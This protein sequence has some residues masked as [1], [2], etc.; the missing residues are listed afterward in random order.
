MSL[1][2]PF[3]NG[4]APSHTA[5]NQRILELYNAAVLATSSVP[6]GT[7][8]L[9]NNSVI[10][11]NWLEC[12]GSPVSRATYAAL[13]AIAG[14]V[15]GAG[16]GVT[17]FNLP[18]LRGRVP[19]GTG[20]GAGLTNRT[21]GQSIGEENHRLTINEMAAHT[22]GG[23]SGFSFTWA[24]GGAANGILLSSSPSGSAGSDTPHNNMQPSIGMRYIVKV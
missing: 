24:T 5:I 20:L 9:N 11:I 13:F 16:D 18:D 14:T 15:F 6:V 19:I 12:D 3:V 2:T 10:P 8:V 7:V 21:L 1:Y 22:H 23:W 4:E 17:T